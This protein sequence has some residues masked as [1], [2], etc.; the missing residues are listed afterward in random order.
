MPI[1]NLTPS[2][3][4]RRKIK[5]PLPGMAFWLFTCVGILLGTQFDD[6]GTWVTFGLIVG[7]GMDMALRS[8]R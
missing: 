8:Q 7:L 1:T 5:V 6:Y 2:S 3:P 4:R